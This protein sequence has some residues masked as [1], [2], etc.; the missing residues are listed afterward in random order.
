M[1]LW[2]GIDEAGYGPR[3]GPLVVA[4]AAFFLPRL[5]RE[6][7]LWQTLQDA[8]C[9]RARGRG[10]RLIINDSKKVY[11]PARGLKRLEEGVLAAL[12]ASS[13]EPSDSAGSL[14]RSL[15]TARYVA[16]A[17]PWFASVSNLS[18]PVAT[19][20]S[21]LE[22]KAD[23]LRRALR[24][25][26]SRLLTVRACVVLPGEFNRVVSHTRNKGLLL[27]QKC[28]LIL[29]QLWR[30]AGPGNSCVVVDRHGGRIHYRRLLKDV[31]PAQSCD[32]L[33]EEEQRSEYRISDGDVSLRI[34]FLQSADSRIL[35]VSLAS[36]TAKYVR[37]LYMLTFNRYWQRR[38][39]DLDPTAGYGRDAWRFVRQ[40]APLLAS[41]GLTESDLVRSL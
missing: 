21:A 39:A 6:G 16:D 32:V 13:S 34:V 1:A 8:V 14:L 22:S 11:T 18:L 41:D 31:F 9:R 10:G 4:G 12:R 40:V 2:A 23:L 33:A 19:N 36:M 20:A 30:S 5:P 29:H 37:E 15:G 3:L 38:K 35:P 24:N 25:R 7:M 28:G 17:P 27:F 26:G